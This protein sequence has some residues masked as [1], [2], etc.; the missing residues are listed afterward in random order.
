MRLPPLPSPC[1]TISLLWKEGENVSPA[2]KQNSQSP[3]LPHHARLTAETRARESQWQMIRSLKLPCPGMGQPHV[4]LWG[5]LA[6]SPL[7][8]ASQGTARVTTHGE[9]GA[10]T[11]SCGEWKSHPEAQVLRTRRWCLTLFRSTGL[12]SKQASPLHLNSGW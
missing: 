7:P 6:W 10:Q 5:E 3:G 4:A 2:T 1:P 12:K 8:I 9:W 11:I